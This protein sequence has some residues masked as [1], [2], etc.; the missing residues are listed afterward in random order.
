MELDEDLGLYLHYTPVI[1]TGTGIFGSKT[2][3]VIKKF[4]AFVETKFFYYSSAV[5][6]FIFFLIFIIFHLNKFQELCRIGSE[7]GDVS[8]T[9]S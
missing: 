3:I 4:F 1:H 6:W 9:L 5:D 2:L 8:A 7:K